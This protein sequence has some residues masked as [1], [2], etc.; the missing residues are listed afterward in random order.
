M[1]ELSRRGLAVAQICT[2]PF[3][4]LGTTQARIY[5][6][7][8]L[9]LAIIPHPLGGLSLDMVEGRALVAIPRMVELIKEQVK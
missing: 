9:P 6:I 2:E 3:V 1:C 4:R 8:D 5:G 7:S